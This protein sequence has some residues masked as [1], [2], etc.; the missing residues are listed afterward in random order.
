MAVIRWLLC[1][2]I[3]TTGALARAPKEPSSNVK[4]PNIIL[5]TL[6]TTRADRMGFLGSKRG[7]TPNLDVLARDSAVFTR[8]YS[9]APL[10]P[11][12]HATILTGTYPQYHQVLTFPVPLAKDMPYLPAILKDHGYSTAAIVGSMAADYEWGVPGF[13]RG[14][15]SYDAG[16]QQE[17]YTPKTRYQTVERRG[18]EVVAHALDWLSEHPQRPFFMWVH[19]Y[20]PHDPYDPPQPYKTRYAKAPYDGEI[21]YVDSVLGK[22]FRQLKAS[23][24]YDDTLVALTADHGEGLGAHGED[25][26]GYFLY[27][28]T[29]HVPLVIKLPHRAT[30]GKRIEDRVELADIM[31]TLLG[32]AGIPVPDKVQGQSLLGFL[33]PETTEGAAAAKSWQDRGAYSQADYGHIAFA[34]SAEQSLRTG[35]YLYIQAPRR[36]LYEDGTDA[37]A[38]HNLAAQSSAVADTLSGK[39][40]DFLQ[41][42]TNTEKTP[43]ARMDEAKA[44]KL[45]VLGYMASRGDSADGAPADAG[46]DPK[47]KI[48]IANTVRKI[49]D[50]IQ[51]FHCEKAVPAIR[52]ALKKYPEIAL[53]HFYIAGC[54]A[55]KEEY[56]GAIPELREAVKLDPGFTSAEKNLGRALMRTQHFDEAMTAF[57]H[58]A[59]SVPS[60][61]DA[62]T[63]LIVL[64][65]KANRQQDVIKECQAV[66]H[67]IPENYG[68]N[69]SLGQALLKTGDAQG[70]IAPLQKA[71]EGEPEK[72]GP[73]MF[74]AD[75]YDKVGRQEDA[76]RERAEAQRLVGAESGGTDAAPESQ[77]QTNKSERQ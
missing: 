70:A 22:F 18:G 24:V 66:L 49:N 27:D 25:A 35:K 42:T 50:T 7:L 77:P 23:G 63:F 40:K 76:K 57:E 55:Q 56:A 64:Y 38:E 28:E 36:E 5:V 69:V 19:L 43:K 13:E 29:I 33:A 59:K 67:Y 73:H 30:V 26:H 8:A 39:I 62:H 3:L 61:V 15:D 1:L 45:A 74:L 14:F 60:D 12:S 65:N 44:Q 46:A 47:D 2:V 34:W 72:P 21:A 31:P 48:H 68:A 4:S 32:F 54:Y 71:I 16:F 9:Q 10:T 6:D 58:V 75:A 52:Q 17:A 11:T 20:D 53:L 51:D 41:T 37:K